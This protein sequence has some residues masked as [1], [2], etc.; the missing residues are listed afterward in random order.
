MEHFA[1]LLDKLYFTSGSLAK[2]DLL[3]QYLRRT[4][5]P[6]RGWA[7]AAIAGTLSFDLFKRH[8]VKQ[9][10]GERMDPLLFEL[11]Y[12]YVGETSETVAHLWPV[13]PG[14]GRLE[15][16][17]SLGEVV[18][19]FRQRDRAAVAD[20]LVQL[21]DAMN[22][23][24]RWALLKLGMRGLRIGI[25]ARLLKRILAEYGSVDVS[26]IE[27]LWH[28]L[29][30]PYT[31][32]LN[33]L[34]GRGDK[35]DIGDRVTFQ[36]V[37]L[38][39]P[40]EPEHHHDIDADNWQ[41]EWK[42]DGIRVQLVGK[43]GGKAL[44]SRSGDDI[45]HS[46]PDI[47]QAV[48]FS[49]VLDGELLVV[50]NG[51]IGSF[52][53]LQQRLNKKKPAK[54]LL[55]ENP[56]GLMIYDAL[57]LDGEDITALS[58]LER[59]RRLAQWLDAKAPPGMLLSPILPFADF[60]ELRRL[61]RRADQGGGNYIEGLML[62]HKHS[63]YLP[64]R[65][66]GHWYKWKREP[67]LVDAVMMYAQRGHGKRSSYYSDYTFGLWQDGQL[68]PIGKAYSGFTDA[69]LKALDKWVRGH[70]V[71]RFGP[72]REV[73]KEL[74]LEVAFD[75]AHTSSRHKSG[76]AL[77]FPRIHRIRWDKPAAEADELATLKKKSNLAG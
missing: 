48:D 70:I 33:W 5:D 13:S 20:Y 19:Q 64:G 1:A 42:Y 59:R 23:S 14:A 57:S 54:R 60:A 10:I 2:G 8:T 6:D 56:A 3:K 17:P 52:N 34:D 31:D 68:L 76:I 36:P 73:E 67:M 12:D 25:S 39:C 51:R 41:A 47:V 44:Y 63:P 30:P 46:F 24:Q 21:L 58:L 29:E 4:P 55:A 9:L 27:A 74:V 38:S 50:R 32:L 49:A 22:A 11:S 53:E 40:L 7:V 66:K 62:K 16:L 69:E 72:V 28:G 18:E 45:S 26:E 75:S 61:H 37:M 65:I 43:A 35:P 15:R 71:A 77:R